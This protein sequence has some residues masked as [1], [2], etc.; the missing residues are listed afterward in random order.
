MFHVTILNPKQVLFE[1]EARSVFLQG[2]EGEFEILDYHAP[3]MSLLRKG[4]IVIDG[5]K[6]LAIKGGAAHFEQNNLVVLA[7]V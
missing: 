1:G 5:G 4:K 2:D 6:Y 7:E 3:I